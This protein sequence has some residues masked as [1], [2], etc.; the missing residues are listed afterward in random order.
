MS[1]T[2]KV[3]SITTIQGHTANIGTDHEFVD[4]NG[5]TLTVEDAR[6]IATELYTAADRANHNGI[7]RDERMNAAKKAH[8]LQLLASVQ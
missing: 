6:A 4:F 7:E 3:V 5:A 8:A 1:R 2:R